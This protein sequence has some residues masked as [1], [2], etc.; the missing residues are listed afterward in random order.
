MIVYSLP[1]FA[2]FLEALKTAVNEN[3]DAFV[4]EPQIS[5]YT[6]NE[7]KSVYSDE[8]LSKLNEY[9]VENKVLTGDDSIPTLLTWSR[10]E[11]AHLPRL[12]NYGLKMPTREDIDAYLYTIYAP[13]SFKASKGEIITLKLGV[14]AV[15]P[16]GK[17][18]LLTLAQVHAGKLLLAS[19][20]I[21]SGRG[22]EL[23]AKFV[24]MEDVAIDKDDKLLKAA[25]VAAETL[26][27]DS[28]VPRAKRT[29]GDKCVKDAT[30]EKL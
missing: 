1:P 14:R 8:E 12:S 16:K 24:A 9:L 25:L 22:D 20:G 26:A 7:C 13:K 17:L 27:T 2:E 11:D 4:K 15:V 23:T 5:E 21:I 18:L 3:A 6:Y 30:S 19:P 10:L 29:R 28:F